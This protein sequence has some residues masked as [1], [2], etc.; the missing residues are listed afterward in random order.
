MDRNKIEKWLCV[1]LALGMT[2]LSSDLALAADNESNQEGSMT[3]ADSGPGPGVTNIQVARRSVVAYTGE[4]NAAGYG[5][6][7]GQVMCC[8]AAH[9]DANADDAIYF[10]TRG[11]QMADQ[12]DFPDDSHAYKISADGTACNIA[13]CVTY[14]TTDITD[15]QTKPLTW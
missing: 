2:C 4:G 6:L 10:G 1:F 13:Q 15:W 8:I 7:A 12:A 5:G 3:L 14:L 9:P 11:S